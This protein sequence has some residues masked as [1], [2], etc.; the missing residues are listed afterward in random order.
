M[1]LRQRL[2]GGWQPWRSS[3]ALVVIPLAL[4]AV[5]T[6]TDVLVPADIHLGPMLVIAPAITAS[7][8]GPRL[9]A[10]IGALTVATVAWIGLHYDVLSSRNVVVQMIALAVL[11]AFIVFFC[12]VRERRRQE[13]DQLRSVAEAAQTVLLRP[14]PHRLGPLRISCLYLAAEHEARIGG[15][16]YA[17]TRTEGGAR[18]IIG[19]VRGKGLAA[20]GE[21]SALLGAFREAAHQHATLPAL[22]V[23]LDRS[24]RRYLAESAEAGGEVVEH[25]ITALL[26][27]IPDE[28]PVI[29]LTSCGHPAPLLLCHGRATPV[30]GLHP[31]PPLGVGAIGLTEHAVDPACF[32][33]GDTLLLYTDGV[34]EARDGEGIFYPLPERAAQWTELGTE[35]LLHQLRHDLL[36]HVGGHLNDDAAVIAIHRAPSPQHGRQRGRIVHH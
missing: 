36:A 21:A 1:G 16:L 8:A 35:A 3:H 33:P 12:R 20:I 6:V 13:L 5:I 25:F 27:D 23:A 9:T 26:L 24:V 30:T 19:D 29:R 34:A 11:S 4:I 10:L 22:A 15:D 31:A 32:E 14:L 18:V 7:F 2:A 17:A 28:E